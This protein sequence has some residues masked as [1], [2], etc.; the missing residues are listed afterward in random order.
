MIEQTVITLLALILAPA[1]GGLLFGVDRKITA[2]L[3]NRVGPP[4]EQPF[5]DF[6]KL[7]SKDRIVANRSQLIYVYVYLGAVMA[8]VALFALQQ[9]LLV[10]L[11]TLAIGGIA[12]VMGGFSVKSPYS[13]IG[14]QRE[15]LQMLAYEPLLI[16]AAVGMYLVTGSFLISSVVA[17]GSPLVLTLPLVVASLVFVLG[18]KMRKSPFDVSMAAHAHQEIV[19]GMLT[20]YSGRYLALIEMAHWYEV[21]LLLGFIALFWA[22][23]IGIGVLLALGL[24]VAVLLID[25]VAARLTWSRVVRL[26]WTFGAGLAVLNLAAIYLAAYMAG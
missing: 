24:F 23:P 8:S 5:Y 16:L 19:R 11:F 4:I 9:D 12:L 7:W 10:I 18:I 15:L 6:I 21:T 26:T 14:S 1:V 22:N 3:Q 13:Q 17:H 20:E 25:N 2:R